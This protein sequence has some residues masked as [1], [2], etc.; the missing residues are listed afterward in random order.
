MSFILLRRNVG[1]QSIARVISKLGVQRIPTASINPVEHQSTSATETNVHL[2]HGASINRH[3]SSI[4]MDSRTIHSSSLTSRQF[5]DT[6]DA[7]TKY[8]I[9]HKS[10]FSSMPVAA[11]ADSPPTA[12]IRKATPKRKKKDAITLTP[13]AAERISDL[14]SSPGGEGAIGIRIGTK[15]RGCN[16]LSYTLNYA[17]EREPNDEETNSHGV[18]LFVEPMAL[19]SI[20]GTVMDWEENDLSSEFTFEN[21]NSKGE[22]G[23]GESFNV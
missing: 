12:K 14:L 13:R 3:R 16:G 19:F 10:N 17:F 21:P 5:I 23:C 6:S 7:S 8:H 4:R 22:C 20:V 1:Q 2:H 18:T 9:T 11:E 15:R